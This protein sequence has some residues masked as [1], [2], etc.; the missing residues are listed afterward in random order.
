MKSHFLSFLEMY[1]SDLFLMLRETEKE[2]GMG[3]FWLS[4]EKLSF[5]FIHS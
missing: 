2:N 4:S 5:T 3:L 1:Q